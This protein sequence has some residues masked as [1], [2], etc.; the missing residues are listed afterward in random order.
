M[1]AGRAPEGRRRRAGGH[2]EVFVVYRPARVVGSIEATTWRAGGFAPDRSRREDERGAGGPDANPL[3]LGDSE[4][5][6]IG[7]RLAPD[8][9]SRR[10]EAASAR[11]TSASHRRGGGV[12]RSGCPRVR[13]EEA[14]ADQA[15]DAVVRDRRL[16]RAL[17]G[18]AWPASW[19]RTART[20]AMSC[21]GTGDSAGFRRHIVW[22]NT[23][24]SGDMPI[25]RPSPR[26]SNDVRP[27]VH[28]RYC[29]NSL[30]PGLMHSSTS[31]PSP[32]ETDVARSWI[33]SARGGI[34]PY[35][36]TRLLG[37]CRA[38]RRIGTFSGEGQVRAG[39]RSHPPGRS[40]R[41]PGTVVGAHIEADVA[42]RR[43]VVRQPEGCASDG[44]C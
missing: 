31:S 30:I 35:P 36:E 24:R 14:G 21:S 42:R 37:P 16:A 6:E 20:A 18:P 40:L 19:S 8:T 7:G 27:G 12:P 17:R 23:A 34:L 11:P 9:R 38:A 39:R 15:Q 22:S 13:A 3:T 26:S 28:R 4:C 25:D 10:M 1:A 32:R 41:S 43:P 5:G 29:N 2:A 44:A 33:R